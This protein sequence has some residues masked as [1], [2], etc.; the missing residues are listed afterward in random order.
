MALHRNR[1]SAQPRGVVQIGS[2]F[3]KRGVRDGILIAGLFLFALSTA[4]PASAGC[5]TGGSIETCTGDL[6]PGV[7]LS[8][9]P[10]TNLN[11]VSL[12]TAI[13][14][15]TG[16]DGISFTGIGSLP[17]GTGS[18]AV[19]YCSIAGGCTITTNSD[20]TSAGY[21]SQSCVL[22]GQGSSDNAACL[23]TIATVGPKGQSGPDLTL[24]YVYPG[25]ANAFGVVTTNASGVFAQSLGSTGGR[26]GNAYVAGDGGNGGPGADGGTVVVNSS[27]NVTTFGN[28]SA[29]VVAY[30]TGGRGGNGGGSYG[31]GGS[32][33]DGG[34]GGY[35]GTASVYVY[36]G[37]ITTWGDQSVGVAAISQGGQGGNGGGGG[38]IA[39]Q[40]GGGSSAGAGNSAL[41]STAAGTSIVT[42][43]DYSHG[44]LAESIGGVGGGGG[45]SFGLFYS[46]GGSGGSGGDGE[47]ATVTASG[48][49]MTWGDNAMG[50]LAES[51]GG[52]GG[53]AGTNAGLVALG[54]SG[55]TG[56]AGGTVS[57]STASSGSIWTNGNSA[58]GLMAQSIG[59]G[60]GNGGSAGGL[61]GIGGSGSI[62]SNGGD[63]TVDNLQMIATNGTFAQAIF[64]Q[65]IGG[66]GGN[67]GTGVG[68][69]SFGGSGGGGGNGGS[70]DV[71]NSATLSTTGSDSSALFAQ[72]I[73]GGGGNGGN[74]Y[75]GGLGV[76]LAIGGS[77]ASG[78]RGGAVT[79]N[80]LLDLT[81][82]PSSTIITTGDRSDGIEAQSIGG[83]GGNGGLA[84]S[85]AV[86]TSWSASVALGGSGG[87]GG[88]SGM[89]LAKELGTISTSG[90][91]ADGIF[92]Q[93]IGGGGGNGGGSVAVSLSQGYSLGF[94]MGGTAGNGG[95]ADTVT[96]DAG[97]SIT[98]TGS[99]SYGVF[100]QSA[101][102]GGGDGGF[103][104][105]AVGTEGPLAASIALGGSGGVGG[106][107]SEVTVDLV[108]ANAQGEIH[109]FGSGSTA[110]FA[111]SVGGGGGN[112]GF[113]VAAGVGGGAI[114]VGLGGK[115]Q[116]G[117]NGSVV[118][119]TNAD[120]LLTQGSMAD[121]IFAQ[122]V[123]GGGGNG[124]FAAAASGGVIGV[125][126][127][128]GGKG[129]GGGNSGAVSVANSGAITTDGALSYG[130]DAQSVGG[131]GGNG[132]F[133]L[134]GALGVQVDDIPGGAAAIS[135][136][137]FAGGGGESDTVTIDNS[138]SI[139]TEGLGSHAIFAQSI[140]GGG[141]TGGIA[142]S[143]GMT[144]GSGAAF[145]VAVGGFGGAGGDGQAV[146]V[147]STGNS[148]VTLANGANGIFAQ[149]IGGGG[150]DGGFAFTGALGF[151]D[152]EN[153]NATVAI[154]GFGS[155]GGTASTVT[156]IS[157]SAI[158]TQGDNS[159]GIFAQS[160]G[161]GGGSGGLAVSGTLGLSETSGNVGVTIGGFAGNG[162]TS[163]NVSVTNSG[164]IATSGYDSIGILAQS[165]GGS[166][167]NGGLA[168]TAQLTG[169][170]KESA[171]VG[172]SIGGGAGSGNAA[173][174]VDVDNLAGGLI[175]TTGF[176]ADGIKAL[177]IGGGGGDGGMAMVAQVGVAG[178]T[179]EQ[180]TKTLNM[181]I[182]VGG[183]GGSGGTGNSVEVSNVGAIT[184]A[185]V[186]ATG[187]F[188]QSIG[189]GGGDGGG[190]LD[191]I[192]MLTDSTNDSSRAVT[193]SV[194]VGGKGGTGN[195]AG[196]VTVDN[197]GAITTKGASGY[198]IFAQSIGGGGG[199]GGRANTMDLMVSDA[200][201]LPVLCTS[202]KSSKNNFQLGVTVGGNGG[203]SGNGNV[204]IVDN[205]GVIATSGDS[206]DG[207][208]AQ[209]V[210]GGG[211][212][213]GNGILGSSQ[214]L[215][216]PVEMAAI[217]VGSVSFYK[218]V[219]VVVGGNAGASGNGGTVS[220]EDS[221]AVTTQGDDS[222]GIFA[223]SIGGGGGIA[224][225]AAIGATGTLGIGGKGG[226]AGNG[227]EVTVSQSGAKIETFGVASDGI[228]AQ[229]VGGGGGVAGNVD[230]ALSSSLS[231]PVVGYTVPALNLGIGLALGQGGG[232]GGNGGNISVS[233]LN[234]AQIITHGDNAAGIFA[235][236]VGGGG[237]VLGDLGDDFPGVSLLSW[238]IG[239]NGDAGNAGTVTVNVAGTIKTS[240]DN[241]TGILAQS[242]GG[243]GTGGDVNVTVTGSVLTGAI[244]AAGD[245]TAA[246]PLRGLGSAAIVAQSVGNAG[247][248]N[249]T[250]DINGANSVVEG[251]NTQLTGSG[252]IGVGIWLIDGNA[253]TVINHG[254]VTT[255]GGVNAGYAIL[256][257]GSGSNAYLPTFNVQNGGN[258]TVENFGTVTGSFD[259]GGGNNSFINEAGAT[260]NT[261]RYAT[262]GSLTAAS[263]L[264]LN[265]G[266]LY[267]G[268]SG[269]VFTTTVLGN[270]KQNASG[271]YGVDLDLYQTDSAGNTI[272]GKTAD[273]INVTGS[274]TGGGNANLSGTVS[275]NIMDPGNARPGSYNVT[276]VHADT[277][278]TTS[279]LTLVAPPSA[280]ASYQ[281]T[282]PDSKS[283]DLSYVIN[284]DPAGLN[285][286]QSAFGA[287]LNKVQ[288]TTSRATPSTAMAPL[289]AALFDL[290]SLSQYAGALNQ[291]VPQVL[292]G[293]SIAT[294]F[295]SLQFSDA[296]MSCHVAGG[297]Y[298]F[299]AENTC[300]WF[301]AAMRNIA[302]DNTTQLSGANETDEGLSLGG[303][304]E[305]SPGLFVGLA[306][307]YDAGS[308]TFGNDSKA[309]GTRYQAGASLKAQLGQAMLGFSL[310]GGAG[311]YDTM[312]QIT[313]TGFG[314]EA[315]GKENM[316]FI[317]THAR[318][319]YAF[320][321]GDFY[322]TPKFDLGMT[323]LMISPYT[324]TGGSL[325]GLAV[326]GQN[327]TF[328]T[329][330]PGLEFGWQF[331]SSDNTV[332]RPFGSVGLLAS[333]AGG[334]SDVSAALANAP[335]AAGTFKVSGRMTG[336]M[337]DN[338]I[339]LEIFKPSGLNVQLGASLQ[340]SSDKRASSF[341]VKLALPM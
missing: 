250:V 223:Q 285:I 108:N 207:I 220:V 222:N 204:V 332:V 131:G 59:G 142:G 34:A 322:L 315:S 290:P 218:N 258:N 212:N 124:G 243:Q 69:V 28:L 301:R 78:G 245:G 221:G 288:L 155:D 255:L 280:V 80:G 137:G 295:S 128:I 203:G 185:G 268:G 273:R 317:A 85:V 71:S 160:V 232:D 176:G 195:D 39:F 225:N 109:T 87:D 166:G 64:A 134:S 27:A 153:L 164:S 303:Q 132:G 275:V 227:G 246:N 267:V 196:T 186:S 122:S 91:Q 136:G 237:G 117:G 194:S 170:T 60:G 135:V 152:E 52:G 219:Q 5:I 129:A 174:T 229:S 279:G 46:G 216:Y 178:G 190:S 130:I 233:L 319:S 339:G 224:G 86:G 56:G 325:A 236:S 9:P 169:T 271:T 150:G 324:E 214:I 262:V 158:T 312:R 67:G 62:T 286:N 20:P 191:A 277:G 189:G 181:G 49:I 165:I 205:T 74:A 327:H 252:S 114:S 51:I 112:G 215:P 154:G 161:G 162:S 96:V 292:T 66:G 266:T 198:G 318:A 257:N 256:A 231:V 283:A 326:A 284:F 260:L 6:S 177:S 58:V 36:G 309:N 230:R 89:V 98:T 138:G 31:I 179:E 200:C 151:G 24:N 81:N 26:G 167:G 102:G 30:S 192:G 206:A 175:A 307:S 73:G 336:P 183:A 199:I 2:F 97:G 313:F 123:G 4:S 54:D 282:Y 259:L 308:S 139:E 38:G 211:G 173:G 3:F 21:L 105:S 334:A 11:V 209:S 210:G 42:H 254:L 287:Y 242:A 16:T 331:T 248:G 330:Q 110:I 127:A 310:S 333:T 182:S 47:I 213:G 340:S 37:T 281:L 305:V 276:I 48:S 125:S 101:G 261:G 311:R 133:A 8:F 92:A 75:S 247:N 1:R 302:Q 297:D 94:S 40:S 18:D 159:V 149:S 143:V 269:N 55:N 119:V 103:S 13:A 272:V 298:K 111:Q 187:I 83:G 337:L 141:G 235:Q 157:S 32:G 93:S 120:N 238:H 188:A 314:A 41:V 116:S 14:P 293:N 197:S 90:A 264:L 316:S 226:A 168:L 82:G 306:A 251:G 7:S 263:N 265:N 43:G 10:I 289:I 329:M 300:L 23:K 341:W 113:A 296:L 63:V 79:V 148:I 146:S 278:V 171:T 338:T 201:S 29:G 22:T 193:V 244:L 323:R 61:V 321:L 65:S 156:V 15:V 106:N 270:W 12:T 95:S 88:N 228:F 19:Y 144:I 57:V 126:A 172:V 304:E 84:V 17:A 99:L 249:I 241:A 294:E 208:Y 50:I 320:D 107:G 118:S 77:A 240:G 104:V 68:L 44:I 291:L 33:G 72:S 274:G 76:S 70:V 145:G 53:S 328:V 121:G 184:V 202:P 335:A 239:S 253:N 217:P 100:A 147:T 163:N 180:A 299:V 35:G 234:Q 115:G 45:G 140:G 25:T